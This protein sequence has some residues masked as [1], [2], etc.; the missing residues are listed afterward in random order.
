MTYSMNLAYSAIEIESIVVLFR[1]LSEC[2]IIVSLLIRSKFMHSY[3]FS[4]IKIL[5]KKIG[6]KTWT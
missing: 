2:T 6:E 4:K 3:A 5:K 1:A